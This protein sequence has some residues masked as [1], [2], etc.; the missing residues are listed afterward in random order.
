MIPFF[1]WALFSFLFL[2]FSSLFVSF[3]VA[4]CFFISSLF[5]VYISNPIH[6]LVGLGFGY[7]II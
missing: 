1:L 2:W 3:R 5:G 4:F 7:V 6:S